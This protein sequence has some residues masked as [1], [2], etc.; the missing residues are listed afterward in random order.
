MIALGAR[1]A[2]SRAGGSALMALQTA[3]PRWVVCA[4]DV[5][6]QN[7]GKLNLWHVCIEEKENNNSWNSTN[8]MITILNNGLW[9]KGTWNEKPRFCFRVARNKC[10]VYIWGRKDVC[11]FNNRHFSPEIWSFHWREHNCRAVWTVRVLGKQEWACC[12]AALGLEHVVNETKSMCTSECFC[13]W[14]V[15]EPTCKGSMDLH[16][17]S[18]DPCHFNFLPLHHSA[19]PGKGEVC[20]SEEQNSALFF[21]R[22]S[23]HIFSH[24]YCCY[25]HYPALLWQRAVGD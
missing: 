19:L 16:F 3:R 15:Y 5:A 21:F 6:H 11:H 10:L 12:A 9:T 2:E 25:H 18:E 17:L 20:A 4:C 7:T 13:V 14:V 24:Y 23:T 1:V 8:I 22:K